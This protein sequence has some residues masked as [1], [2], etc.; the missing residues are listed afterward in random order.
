MVAI[1]IDVWLA[2][3]GGLEKNLQGG[4]GASLNNGSPAPRME[5]LENR[6][7]QLEQTVAV[8]SSKERG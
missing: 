3:R 7:E 2:E 1:V 8:L 5:T 4:D 6:V